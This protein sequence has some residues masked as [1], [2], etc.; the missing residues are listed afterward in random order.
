MRKYTK[1]RKK[2]DSKG[3]WK[4]FTKDYREQWPTFL[5]KMI[6]KHG[7]RFVGYIAR[8]VLGSNKFH[9]RLAIELTGLAQSYGMSKNGIEMFSS[10][11]ACV[12]YKTIDRYRARWRNAYLAELDTK[13]QNDDVFCIW[14]DQYVKTFYA[15]VSRGDAGRYD[16][17]KCTVVGV[18]YTRYPDD[19]I[20]MSY[21]YFPGPGNHVVP[22]FSSQ[23]VTG[24]YI[25]AADRK[26]KDLHRAGFY[27]DYY[28]THRALT[29]FTSPPKGVAEE[30]EDE[31]FPNDRVRVVPFDVLKPDVVSSMGFIEAMLDLR[32][33]FA[34]KRAAGKYYIMKMDI[35]LYAKFY[36]KALSR[37]RLFKKLCVD[38]VLL[39]PWWHTCKICMN[40]ITD[41]HF[42][43]FIAPAYLAMFPASK[44]VRMTLPHQPLES[45]LGSL[46][47]AYSEVR[48]LFLA[49]YTD[50][51]PWPRNLMAV[52]QFFEY[53][54]PYVRALCVL[55]V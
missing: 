33:R 11:G 43:S 23:V 18:T 6:K 13:M 10:N 29:N 38:K 16:P 24:H 54:L 15:T 3:K 31:A 25:N 32:D 49:L 55:S 30:A 27:R 17:A 39:L 35:D 36:S 34:H 41:Y 40:N 19:P 46:A 44:T 12:N 47:L 26:F 5:K 53:L 2:Y 42:M 37:E 48:P 50:I 21:V 28:N 8:A 20:D 9:N 1:W 7:S 14:V 22:S 4:K 51:D 45:F 52:Y